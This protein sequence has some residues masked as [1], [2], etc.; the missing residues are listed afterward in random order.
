VGHALR[1]RPT[2]RGAAHPPGPCQGAALGP[3]SSS[4]ITY[5]CSYFVIAA[6]IAFPGYKDRPSSELTV[7]P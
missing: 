7:D 2:A 5:R 3:E 6:N 4:G 1:R